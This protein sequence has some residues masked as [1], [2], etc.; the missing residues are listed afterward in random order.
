MR[1]TDQPFFFFSLCD[2]Y[3]AVSTPVYFY[4]LLEWYW[5]WFQPLGVRI[6]S[7]IVVVFVAAA[8]ARDGH[9]DHHACLQVKGCAHFDRK[10]NR[11]QV[12]SE[13]VLVRHDLTSSSRFKSS[14]GGDFRL[15]KEV[16]IPRESSSRS[17]RVDSTSITQKVTG[18]TRLARR[19]TSTSSG[20]RLQ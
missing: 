11:V 1:K 17:A 9:F 19:R 12:L 6:V 4:V 20:M 3:W 7:A 16:T 2:I 18:T 10:K 13:A 15:R 5:N 14:S 8:A